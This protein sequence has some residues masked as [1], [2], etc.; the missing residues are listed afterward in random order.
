MYVVAQASDQGRGEILLPVTHS[1]CREAPRP[2]STGGSS[3]PSQRQAPQAVCLWEA[4][5][6]EAVEGY[7]DSLTGPAQ[8]ERVL[9]GERG[10]HDRHPRADHERRPQ[11][12][13]KAMAQQLTFETY[14]R[15]RSGELRALLRARDRSTA[16]GRPR[17]ISQRFSPG[18]ARGRTSPVA[19]ALWR[20]LAAERV[21]A[22]GTVCRQSIST[23]ECWRS[24]AP[25]RLGFGESSGTRRA[26]T[27]S[28][29]PTM[30]STSRSARSG[31]QF[32]PEQGRLQFAR[33]ASRP[34]PW[35]P[36]SHQPPRSHAPALRRARRQRSTRHHRPRRRGLR[37]RRVLASRRRV[38]SATS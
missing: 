3:V 28:R 6:V 38:R 2:A 35:G 29:F 22:E 5:S 10:A 19:P 9:P 13:D 30:H 21:G 4:D 33:C 34:C 16:G 25:S 17:R 12:G 18:D 11:L 36:A 1:G 32:I 26:P 7:L 15:Q 8:R 24:P 20:R 23:R 14:S 27:R 37:A 31:L